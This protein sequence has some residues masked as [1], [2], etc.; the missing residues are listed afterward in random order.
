VQKVR[1]PKGGRV[2]SVTN[3]I[4]SV[5]KAAEAGTGRNEEAKYIGT[6]AL[7]GTGS[8]GDILSQMAAGKSWWQC[9]CRRL[10]SASEPNV[11]QSD[12]LFEAEAR[13]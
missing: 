5:V 8:S 3:E 6:G 4:G 13:E 11:Q 9:G 1:Q 10:S 12:G 2:A 7:K